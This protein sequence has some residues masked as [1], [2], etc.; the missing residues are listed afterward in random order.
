MMRPRWA[1]LFCRTLPAD[2][3]RDGQ[4]RVRV[5][6]MGARH[7]RKFCREQERRTM[8]SCRGFDERGGMRWQ[9]QGPTGVDRTH[10]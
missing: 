9:A 7:L 5:G 2:L 6:A 4:R 8:E 1:S 3:G 10:T